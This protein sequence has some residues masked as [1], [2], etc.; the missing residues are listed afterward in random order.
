MG[1]LNA[2][3]SLLVYWKPGGKPGNTKVTTRA[4]IGTACVFEV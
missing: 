1:V 2:L 3:I 4:E